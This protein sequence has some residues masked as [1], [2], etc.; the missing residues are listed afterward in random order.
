MGGLEQ[1]LIIGGG[2]VLLLL[3]TFLLTFTTGCGPQ[4]LLS[5]ESRWIRLCKKRKGWNWTTIEPGLLLG[6][7]PRTPSHL[8]ELK[9]EGVGAVL[10]L[11]E[12]WEVRLTPRCMEDCDMIS[13]Q[14]RTPDFFAPSQRD[15]LEAVTFIHAN[16][17]KGVSVYVHCN[18]GK[19][20]SAVCVICYLIHKHGWSP[21]E[22]FEFVKGKR[23]IA[24]MKAWCGLHKQWRAVK[25]FDRELKANRKQVAYLAPG[26]P[27][28][29][30]AAPK[31]GA[32]R[33][34]P[35]QF[36]LPQEAVGAD[37][38]PSP[39]NSRQQHLP[40]LHDSPQQAVFPA[41]PGSDIEGQRDN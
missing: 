11:N 24:K 3:S 17:Q 9:T 23:K 13:R 41:A 14:L 16:V 27:Q 32:A 8:E 12:D 38:P 34:V 40:P 22:A 19:G 36:D 29:P 10:T 35:M 1:A 4:W 37:S 2:S 20:R 30:R 25:R 31:S 18:G 7:L 6:T 33:V 21:E 15:I 39:D 26:E 28:P 5:L